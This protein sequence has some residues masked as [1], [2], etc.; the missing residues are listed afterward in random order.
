[1]NISAIRGTALMNVLSLLSSSASI[2]FCS[3]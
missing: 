1:M 2:R 3:G